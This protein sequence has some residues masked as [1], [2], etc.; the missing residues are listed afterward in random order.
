M[1]TTQPY[2]TGP[3]AHAAGPRPPRCLHCP[4][5]ATV[6]ITAR[7]HDLYR[8]AAACPAHHAKTHAWAARAGPVEETPV[9]DQE[10]TTLF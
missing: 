9:H 5:A 2:G 1:T 8:S 3:A 6:T 10:L 4:A 7:G